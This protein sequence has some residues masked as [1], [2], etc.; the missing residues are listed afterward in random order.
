MKLIRCPVIGDCPAN[1]F[2]YGGPIDT[3]DS[4]TVVTTSGKD[5][6]HIDGSAAVKSEWWYHTPSQN[7]FIV[8]RNTAN[9]HIET[10]VA[11]EEYFHG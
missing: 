7:W 8:T 10:V 5:I 9:D 6:F 4:Q 1:E 2:V 3:V 11:A